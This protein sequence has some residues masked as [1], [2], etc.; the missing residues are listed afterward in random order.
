M[1][2]GVARRLFLGK[3]NQGVRET[4]YHDVTRWYRSSFARVLYLLTSLM[5][6][7]ARFGDVLIFTCIPL[8]FLE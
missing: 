8:M 4:V 2:H 5:K 7:S 3:D 6:T 1:G